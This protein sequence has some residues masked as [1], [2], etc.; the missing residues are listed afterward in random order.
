M[1][2]GILDPDSGSSVVMAVGLIGV[3]VGIY[4]VDNIDN[5]VF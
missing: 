2:E 3:H 5:S 4:V 1:W